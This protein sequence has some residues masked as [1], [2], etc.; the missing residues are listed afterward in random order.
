VCGQSD[1]IEQKAAFGHINFFYL[2]KVFSAAT[3]GVLLLA[4]FLSS[5][6]L[7]C[8]FPLSPEEKGDGYC[9]PFDL[10]RKMGTV[11]GV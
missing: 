3:E 11:W 10:G 1:A 4:V 8:P 6:H 2:G 5:L 7:S 9:D